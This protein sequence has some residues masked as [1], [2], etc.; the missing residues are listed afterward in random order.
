MDT[1][2]EQKVKLVLTLVDITISTK[3]KVEN[4]KEQDK[5]VI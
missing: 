4:L 2:T 3:S 5:F 1:T